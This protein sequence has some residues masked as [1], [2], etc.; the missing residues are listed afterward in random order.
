MM[1]GAAGAMAVSELYVQTQV[2]VSL[3]GGMVFVDLWDRG[4]VAM[5]GTWVMDG[6][7]H[8]YPLNMSKIVCRAD[9]KQC[10]D[11]QATVRA[12]HGVPLLRVNED[13]HEI[14]RW[15]KDT[16]I[17]Q[18]NAG[19][20]NYA[21]TVSRQTKQVAGIRTIKAG[22]DA[23]CAGASREIKLRLTNGFD[24]YYQM[25]KDA[26]P[27]A[28]NIAVLGLI[29]VWGVVRT[30]NIWRPATANVDPYPANPSAHRVR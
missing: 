3:Y 5:E 10:I 8:A 15:D 14:A 28:L 27:V 11:S 30:K 19:C 29:L 9:T 12:G 17:Y 1:I 25:Q 26:R 7:Q 20:V 13:L 21:Y 4:Y 18:T 16:L 23:T 2:P 6:D 22:A 24:I